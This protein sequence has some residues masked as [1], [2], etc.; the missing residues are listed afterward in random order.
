MSTERYIE[1]LHVDPETFPDVPTNED[2]IRGD[3]TLESLQRPL[4]DKERTG[5]LEMWRTSKVREEIASATDDDLEQIVDECGSVLEE[6]TGVERE[7]FDRRLIMSEAQNILARRRLYPTQ[8]TN[9]TE[10]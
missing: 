6:L 4:T 9:E 1:M 2:I 5:F 3:A 7:I 10:E 8:L